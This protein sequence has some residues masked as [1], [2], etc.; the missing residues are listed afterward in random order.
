MHTI[1]LRTDE[2]LHHCRNDDGN[3]LCGGAER[4]VDKNDRDRH[5]NRNHRA[6][7]WDEVEEECQHAEDHLCAIRLSERQQ[8][9]KRAR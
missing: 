2:A 1:K 9:I 5:N 6:N 8:A 4:V 3:E 7:V